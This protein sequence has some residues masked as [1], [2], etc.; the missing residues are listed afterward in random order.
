[1]L[2]HPDPVHQ[3]RHQLQGGQI[4]GQQL[5][6]GMLGAGHEP[7]RHRRL[8]GPR[9]RALDLCADR[10]QPD[11]VAAGRQLG[12]HPLQRE[13]VEQLGGGERLVARHGQLA[14]AVSGPDPRTLDPHPAAT[15]GHPARL[16]AMSDRRPVRVVAAPGADQPSDVLLE[17][18][19][20]HL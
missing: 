10:F 12:Q 19:L 8:G 2:G 3:Q 16:A 6:Q 17:H 4:L 13:L 5:G 20:E 7:A 11:P 9:R 18:D 1:M 14:G 15:Q